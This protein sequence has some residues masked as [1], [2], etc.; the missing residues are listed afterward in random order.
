M[1]T[2]LLTVDRGDRKPMYD[3]CLYQVSRFVTS[4]D[5]HI[6]IIRPPKNNAPDLTER[7]YEGYLQA[8]ELGIDWIIMI[9]SDDFYAK[10][11]LHEVMLRF[12]G[13][14]FVGSEFTHY[15][16]LQNRTWERSSHPNHS[17]L[18]TTAFRVSALKDFKWKSASKVFL[19]IDLWIY[20]RNKGLR[21]K[22]V[23]LPA[24]GIK[25]HGFGLVG[26]K[27]H[28]QTFKNKDPEMKWLKSKVDEESFEFYES[29]SK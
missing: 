23:D 9:E 16:H 8:V 18:F 22:F 6:Q 1:S 13:A 7:V 26:G 24:I 20:A 4:F 21:R 29:L 12:D 28:R 27:G 10:H 19:D 14:D 5:R 25:G 11:Y 2:A 15:Y 3:H 17:S